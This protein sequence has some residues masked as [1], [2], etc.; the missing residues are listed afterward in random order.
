MGVVCSWFA[1]L[2]HVRN[3]LGLIVPAQRNAISPETGLVTIQLGANPAFVNVAAP[4][5]AGAALGSS[6]IAG[7]NTVADAVDRPGLTAQLTDVVRDVSPLGPFSGDNAFPF[8]P[9]HQG[10]KRLSDQVVAAVR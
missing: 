4:R 9:T 6:A 2:A 3:K 8:H 7:C 5:C 1:T 10:H